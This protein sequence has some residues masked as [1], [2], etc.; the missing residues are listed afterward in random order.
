[1]RKLNDIQYC[2]ARVWTSKELAETVRQ[3]KQQGFIVTKDGG[4]T[5]IVNPDADEVVLRS[6]KT[7]GAELV[8]LDQGYFYPEYEKVYMYLDEQN[9]VCYAMPY[10][11]PTNRQHPNLRRYVVLRRDLQTFFNYYELKF[12][13]KIRR[14]A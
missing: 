4:M 8:R 7:G 3:C 10:D 6:A 5:T 1:M 9:F 12:H 14:A 13:P 11:T 2:A